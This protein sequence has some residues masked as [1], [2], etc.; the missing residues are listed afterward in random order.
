MIQNVATFA[1]EKCHMDTNAANIKEL[2]AH[3]QHVALSKKHPM[4]Y[5]IFVRLAE[6]M[7]VVP[8]KKKNNLIGTGEN[9]R[10]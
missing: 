8:R 5:F 9:L 2:F 6:V 4:I 10:V 3:F 1:R 7:L